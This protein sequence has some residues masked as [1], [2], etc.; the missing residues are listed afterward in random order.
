MVQ[1]GASASVMCD[2][3]ADKVTSR[4]ETL[5]LQPRHTCMQPGLNALE[6]ALS[7]HQFPIAHLLINRA[8]QGDN[9]SGS[10]HLHLA[11][12]EGDADAVDFLLDVPLGDARALIASPSALLNAVFTCRSS[13]E[14]RLR[15]IST[16]R[17]AGIA[18]ESFSAANDTSISGD[19]RALLSQPLSAFAAASAP[20]VFEAVASGSQNVLEQWLACGLDVA[21][22]LT[23]D[24][25]TLMHTCV[26]K[27]YHHLLKSILSHS[28][29]AGSVIN[30]KSSSGLAPLHAASKL[31]RTNCISLLLSH[32][33]DVNLAADASGDRNTALLLAAAHSSHDAFTALL[34]SGADMMAVNRLGLNVVHVAAAAGNSFA[35]QSIFSQFASVESHRAQVQSLLSSVS[36]YGDTPL[37]L[38]VLSSG[39]LPLKALK[40]SFLLLQVIVDAVPPIASAHSSQAGASPKIRNSDGKSCIELAEETGRRELS[41]LFRRAALGAHENAYKITLLNTAKTALSAGDVNLFADIL[42]ED[43]SVI[44]HDVLPDMEGD[45]CLHFAATLPYP[46]TV[47]LL[48]QQQPSP[49]NTVGSHG[50]SSLHFASS[51]GHAANVRFLLDARADVD[52]VANDGSTALILACMKGHTSVAQ[53]LVSSCCSCDVLDSSGMAAIHHAARACHVECISVLAASVNTLDA[54]RDPPLCVLCFAVVLLAYVNL[55]CR[56]FSLFF[57]QIYRYHALISPCNIDQIADAVN[58]LLKLGASPIVPCPSAANSSPASVAHVLG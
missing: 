51:F 50:R 19:I 31:N 56:Y 44:L 21:T 14:I 1:G 52:A 55:I 38:C 7:Y 30:T 8:P 58:V 22:C 18:T 9:P 27:D 32:S 45:T 16:L 47:S 3:S 33:A 48:L 46:E 42:N 15:M 36:L 40:C 28:S 34:A 25:S 54:R 5:G 13:D 4:L 57:N 39:I 6:M 24:G 29:C 43:S 12:I 26:A 20:L 35:L 49:V 23:S 17:R 53:A 2:A 37:H 41:H 11:I 10:T